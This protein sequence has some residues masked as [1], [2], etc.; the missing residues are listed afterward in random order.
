MFVWPVR[1]YIEDTDAG[2]IVY[3][4]NYLRFM[5]RA[6]TEFL[7]ESQIEQSRLARDHD[8]VFV[9]RSANVD[10]LSPARMDDE[11][12]IGVEILEQRRASL[13]FSQPV[14]RRGEP[15]EK[16][17]CTGLVRIACI[18]QSSGRPVP[19]PTEVIE[20]LHRER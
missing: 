9:V 12:Q 14:F 4:A 19:V 1:V 15:L 5:E 7:R 3:Y 11:L 13:L 16:P 20:A 10:Y 8:L 17:I 2:G 18:S 6:R